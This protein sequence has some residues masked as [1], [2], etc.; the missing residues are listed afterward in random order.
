MSITDQ[1]LALLVIY[2]LPVLFTVI[3]ICSVGIPFPVSLV[4]VA[5]G[6]FVQQGEMSLWSVILV[7]SLAAILGDQVG[8]GL[9]R[10]CGRRLVGKI[11]R[12]LGVEQ[13]IQ[14]AERF[15]RRWSGA[16]IFLSRWL[17]TALG[18][19]VNITSG[20]AGYPWQ[21][22]LLWDVVGELLW[23]VLYV[24]LGYLF[25]NR[26]Q[27][28]VEIMGNLAWVVLGLIVAMFLGWK[29]VGYVRPGTSAEC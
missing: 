18:P 20:I 21:R 27:A 19:W 28:M 13:Q 7:A 1:V 16:G 8:Y 26:V 3:V 24:M 29:V 14:Q 9:A 10:W 25:S 17:I 12:G 15:T 22:F 2:G 11:S 6:S 23:V 4:L 5:A